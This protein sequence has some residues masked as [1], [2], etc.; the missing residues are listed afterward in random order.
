MALPMTVAVDCGCVCIRACDY[1]LPVVAVAVAVVMVETAVWLWVGW[2]CVGWLWVGWLWVEVV[3]EVV[4]GGS[5]CGCGGSRVRGG[6]NA[7][8]GCGYLPPPP[9]RP[10]SPILA[11]G[12]YPFHATETSITAGEGSALLFRTRHHGATDVGPPTQRKITKRGR[13]RQNDERQP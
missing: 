7:S 9:P 8:G 12:I 11:E 4:V 10:Q 6:G 1:G 3:V 5:C 2:L 13:Q